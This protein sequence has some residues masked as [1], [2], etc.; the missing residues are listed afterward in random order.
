M[1]GGCTTLN[2]YH[3]DIEKYIAIYATSFENIFVITEIFV[4]GAQIKLD[5]DDD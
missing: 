4:Y 2:R 3:L 1:D 5:F